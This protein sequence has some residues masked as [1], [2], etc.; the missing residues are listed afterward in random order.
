MNAKDNG[1]PY[2]HDLRFDVSVGF[3]SFST[4]INPACGVICPHHIL[5]DCINYYPI[6]EH[7][8]NGLYKLT[9]MLDDDKILKPVLD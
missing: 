1:L 9:Y 7:A 4:R 6:G 2:E 3:K 5:F 8:G